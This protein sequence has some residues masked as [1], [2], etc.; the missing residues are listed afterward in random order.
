MFEIINIQGQTC[1]SRYETSQY[2]QEWS[3]AVRNSFKKKKRCI[4][5]EEKM[6]I[7]NL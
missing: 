3:N 5:V 1:V 7:M 6:K 2:Y 4:M